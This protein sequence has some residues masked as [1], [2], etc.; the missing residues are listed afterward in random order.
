MSFSFLASF[1]FFFPALIHFIFVSNSTF[2]KEGPPICWL[3][4]SS[5]RSRQMY[6]EPCYLST[7]NLLLGRAA[8]LGTYRGTHRGHVLGQLSENVGSSHKDTLTSICLPFPQARSFC[9][10]AVLWYHIDSSCCIFC[11]SQ[12]PFFSAE[13]DLRTQTKQLKDSPGVVQL[14]RP[15]LI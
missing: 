6:P 3:G 2:M 11:G 14:S 9:L 1:L 12:C 5:L 15:H 4:Y 10:V 7:H 13:Q 8:S